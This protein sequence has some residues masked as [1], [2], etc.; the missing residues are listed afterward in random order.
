MFSIDNTQQRTMRS[1]FRNLLTVLALFFAV[2]NTEAFT[3]SDLDDAESRDIVEYM[4][5]RRL[6]SFPPPPLFEDED[7]MDDGED[8]ED[9]EFGVLARAL[10]NR[11]LQHRRLI[12]AYSS[13]RHGYYKSCKTYYNP[14]RKSCKCKKQAVVWTTR[15]RI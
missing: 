15:V 10:T 1:H 14:Y 6:R 8:V 7:G 4:A 13:C 12:N 3:D 2:A 5:L 11:R 9:D